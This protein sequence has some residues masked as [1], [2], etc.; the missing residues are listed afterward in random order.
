MFIV[1]PLIKVYVVSICNVLS[2]SSWVCQ[3]QMIV[4]ISHPYENLFLLWTCSRWCSLR[5]YILQ[6]VYTIAK[7]GSSCERINPCPKNWRDSLGIKNGR[8]KERKREG[9]CNARITSIAVH[10]CPIKRFSACKHHNPTI[11][12][13]LIYLPIKAYW[14]HVFQGAAAKTGPTDVMRCDAGEGKRERESRESRER[15]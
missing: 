6:L 11:R 13:R 3:A 1:L 15:F 8:A 4:R 14:K 5:L 2:S 12:S 7:A 10:A 9:A